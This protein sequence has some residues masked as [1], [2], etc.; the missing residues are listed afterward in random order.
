MTIA[1][2]LAIALQNARLLAQERWRA[3][4][5]ARANQALQ[6]AYEQLVQADKLASLGTLAG[7]IVHDIANP[8]TVILG[9][10]QMLRAKE[11]EPSSAAEHARLIER[12][13]R[14]ISQLLQTIRNFA[15][16][17]SGERQFVDIHEPIEEA[18]ILVGKL[19]SNG[20]VEIVKKYTETLPPVWADPN[21]LEQ[22]C[23]NLIQNAGQA[24]PK[25][26]SKFHLNNTRCFYIM[27][28]WVIW[29]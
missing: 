4:E 2:Q 14:K 17:H 5:L 13:G 16:K 15:R 21:E 8:L 18:L 22:V 23:M 6:E 20:K 25:E 1:D 3:E 27:K 19:L 26:L 11:D 7:T 24:M 28:S 9:E 10:A 29:R 12:Y